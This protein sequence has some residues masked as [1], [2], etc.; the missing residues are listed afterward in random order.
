MALTVFVLD[1]NGAMIMMMFAHGSLSCVVV[2]RGSIQ[3]WSAP[4]VDCA[5]VGHNLFA[6]QFQRRRRIVQGNKRARV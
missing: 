6:V 1:S 5:A 3:W 4:I 2:A